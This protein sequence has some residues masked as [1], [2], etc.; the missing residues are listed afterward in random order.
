MAFLSRLSFHHRIFVL[1]GL[2][3]VVSMSVLW[4]VIRP[5]YERQVTEER[6]T[7]VQQLQHFA[8]RSI[9]ERLEQWI[10]VAQYLS[11]N[12]QTRPADAGV[13]IRQQI[14]FDTAIVQIIVSSPDLADEFSATSSARPGFTFTPEEAMWMPA[15]NDTAVSVLWTGHDAV[16]PHLFGVRR[17]FTIGTGTF[18]LT[19]FTETGGML[20]Q[21]EQLPVGGAFSVQV[22]GASGTVFSN[23]AF[24]LPAGGDRGAHVNVIR[25]VSVQGTE[26]TVLI[27]RFLS[28]P[29]QMLIA[30]P[31]AVI[32]QPVQAL[33]LYSSLVAVSVTLAVFVI[34]WYLSR[35]I[36]QPV[37]RLVE[38]VERLK[39]LDFTQ[40][41]TVPQLREIA[42]V[43]ETV[44]S[45]RTVLE[46]YQRINVERI[47][48]EEWKNK[49][50]LSHSE[51]GISITDGNDAF[52]FM[53]DRFRQITGL[54]ETHA[55]AGTK[56]QLLAH[57]MAERSRETF[58]EDIS[59]PYIIHFHQ[60]E[61]LITVPDHEAQYYRLHDVT[62]ARGDERLGSLIV[63]HDL[64]NERNIDKMKTEMMNFIVHE[65]RNPLNS[66]MGFSSFIKDEP[67]MD[68]RERMEYITIIQESSRTMNQ[69]VNRF[70]DV[71]RLESRSVEYHRE[72]TD[73]VT[74]AKLVCDSQKPQLM[75]KS[76]D[77]TF[78]A[79][80]GIPVTTI[81]PDLMRE[82]FLNLVSNAIK[83]GDEHRTIEVVMKRAGDTILF[84]ITDHG[85]GISAEDQEKLFSKFFRVTSN[86]KS[87]MQ[88]GTGLGLAHVK[89]VM[90]FHK[91]EVSLESSA[92]LGCRFTLTI[93]IV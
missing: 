57:P 15:G 13:L 82:A 44:E 60:S 59:G 93:P 92:E 89:E 8:V 24:E 85:Y 47:I 83:Y 58:R 62:I 39:S 27:T 49:F 76:I 7:V 35:Q 81:S 71:Q 72:P 28:I 16:H 1:T 5:R 48:V 65:L 34:G 14:A 69:L 86:K 67:E 78:T 80:P 79:E 6:T 54:L 23:A 17:S 36:T 4:F 40:P 31:S 22:Q 11:W 64:T 77:L 84:I 21:L 46:R 87:A 19:M 33:L 3:A 90:K 91:G 70:L 88:I 51:D 45:M 61:L 63:L 56:E 38:D 20:R 37:R 73:L 41:V 53:N 30:V 9:D 68:L 18:T 32:L 75:A 43:A 25:T 74:T 29:M 66:I 52:S 12:L 55:P 2:A 10:T 42:A 26:W 50:F